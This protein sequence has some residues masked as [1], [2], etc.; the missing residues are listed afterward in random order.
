MP[1]AAGVSGRTGTTFY[2]VCSNA[3]SDCSFDYLTGVEVA[4]G[5]GAA[6][7]P[8]E[9]K[10]LKLPARRIRRLCSLGPRIR[11]FQDAG[12]NLGPVGRR[13]AG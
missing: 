4:A 11:D 1:R 5:T 13:I 12:D 9:F 8:G 2:G 10:S 6:H 3:S 7:L